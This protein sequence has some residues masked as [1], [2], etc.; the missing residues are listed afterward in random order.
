MAVDANGV[1]GNVALGVDQV[2]EDAAGR[3]LVDDLD[4]ADFEQPMALRRI[5]AG[6]FGVEHDLTHGVSSVLPVAAAA[7]MK[8]GDLRRGSHPRLPPVSMTKCARRRF[9]AS[10]I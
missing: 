1:L 6:R 2:M 10:L 3:G 5:E 7:R 4:G 9:S 8:L